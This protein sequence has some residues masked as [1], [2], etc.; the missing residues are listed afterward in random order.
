MVEIDDVGVRVPDGRMIVRMTV[1]LWRF[2][3]FVRVLMVFVVDVRVFVLECIVKMFHVAR[4]ASRPQN[5]GCGGRQQ[6]RARQDAEGGCQT[7]RSPD[8]SCQWI[9]DQPAGM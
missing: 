3:P 6:R 4:I 1:G 2:P 9:G 5:N 7:E 8:P